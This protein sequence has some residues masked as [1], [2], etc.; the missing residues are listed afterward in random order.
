MN[1][2]AHA[3]L[4]F[5]KPEVLAGNMISDFVKGKKQF[6]YPSGIQTGIR[7][8]RDIDQ[9][10]D[11]HA[12]TRAGKEVFRNDYRLY[13]GAF[14]DVVYD[15]FLAVDQNEFP[16]GS[17][18]AFTARTYAMLEPFIPLVP[19]NFQQ[20]F[21]YMKQHNWL[22]NYQFPAGIEKSMAGLVRRAAWLTESGTAFTIF[23]QHYDHL[24]Q[25]YHQFFPELKTFAFAQLGAA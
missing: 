9:F 10:T 7:L 4:S 14:M 22:Y 11:T 15:H 21:P 2:L 5:D 18:L 8:H 23:K 3:Y 25:C 24:Q 17:L 13:A 12:A 1:Y 19:A 20:M 16:E 6:D